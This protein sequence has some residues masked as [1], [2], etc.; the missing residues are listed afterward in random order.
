MA[1]FGL[2]IAGN[3][4]IWDKNPGFLSMVGR[5]KCRKSSSKCQK[6]VQNLWFLDIFGWFWA[7]YASNWDISS[8]I[9]HIF[10]D[11]RS[12]K[13]FSDLTIFSQFRAQNHRFYSIL[14]KKHVLNGKIG[15]F[16]DFPDF[17][18]LLHKIEDFMAIWWNLM[19]ITHRARN[20]LENRFDWADFL[21]K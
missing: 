19:R 7:K 18:K 20:F 13:Y 12:T 8:E 11:G 9:G 1:H 14:L 17:I 2:K 3:E 5:Q 6:Y 15:I 21:Q 16:S 10:L 4:T